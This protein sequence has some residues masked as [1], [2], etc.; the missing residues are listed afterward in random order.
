MSRSGVNALLYRVFRSASRGLRRTPLRHVP[1]LT[2]L[3]SRIFASARP[4][5]PVTVGPFL[6][7]VDPRDTVIAK[8]LALYGEF[9]PYESTV[10][11]MLLSPGDTFIDAGAN[12]GLHTL[13]AS[14]YV[15]TSGRVLAIEPDPANFAILVQNLSVNGCANVEPVCKALW[16]AS[17][18]MS[19]FQNPTNRGYLSLRD[20]HGTGQSVEVDAVSLDGLLRERVT[21]LAAIKLDVEGAELMALE[22]MRETLRRNPGAALVV[23]LAPENAEAFGYSAADLVDALVATGRGLELIDEDG[24]RLV[25]VTAEAAVAHARRTRADVNLLCRAPARG[26]PIR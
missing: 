1:W 19:L 6:M 20:V 14:R 18:T 2:R 10:L 7:H 24:R 12:I 4:P 17:G 13:W 3:H 5:G 22:G 11:G 26:G 16:S 21:R 23:E 9:E 15:G 25:P 8:K